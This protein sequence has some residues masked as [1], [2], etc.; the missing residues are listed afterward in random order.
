MPT[1]PSVDES[2]DR[3]CRADWSVGE[4]ATAAGWLVT[5]S[6]GDVD[7]PYCLLGQ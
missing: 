6:N 1:Y 2:R 5:A 7:Q 4:I 3:L